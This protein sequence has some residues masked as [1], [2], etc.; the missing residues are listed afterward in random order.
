MGSS[1]FIP[2]IFPKIFFKRV[3]PIKSSKNFP[4]NFCSQHHTPYIAAREGGYKEGL[5]GGGV[6]R[7]GCIGVYQKPL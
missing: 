7:E 2:K 4:K 5:Q 1:E 6:H 3:G